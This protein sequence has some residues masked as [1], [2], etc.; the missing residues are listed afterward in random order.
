MISVTFFNIAKVVGQPPS[1]ILIYD[2]KITSGNLTAGPKS[3]GAFYYFN[4][5]NITDRTGGL[6]NVFARAVT[7]TKTSSQT[8]STLSTPASVVSINSSNFTSST[9][10]Q[11]SNSP[12][13]IQQEIAPQFLNI[14][15]TICTAP[16]STTSANIPQLDIYVS[17][18]VELPGPDNNAEKYN[19]SEGLSVISWP[20]NGNKNGVYI[21]I[22]A[23]SSVTGTFT[24]QI[25]TSLHESMHSY[26]DKNSGIYL[27]DTDDNHALVTTKDAI[28]DDSSYHVYIVPENATKGLSKSFCALS[29]IYAQNQNV[30]VA[31]NNTITRGSNDGNTRKSAY[32]DGLNNGT[33]YTV[34][35]V[36][37]KSE[38]T[39]LMKPLLINTKILAYAVPGN[40]SIEA[41]NLRDFYDKGTAGAFKNFSTTLDQY[42]CQNTSYSLVRNCSDCR[43]DYKDWLCAVSI[44]RCT[45]ESSS[46]QGILR[47][48]NQSRNP[49]IDKIMKPGSYK[50][51]LPCIELCYK[52]V[53][54]CPAFLLFNCPLSKI[55]M[56]SS[57]N[58]MV[59][60]GMTGPTGQKNS[61]G[62]S[63]LCNAM[64]LEWLQQSS[65]ISKRNRRRFWMLIEHFYGI[66]IFCELLLIFGNFFF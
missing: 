55:T 50:E 24:F 20:Y 7:S 46:D 64:G 6:K 56:D 16:N 23:P 12:D 32:F 25:G 43:R 27:D 1:T 30:T 2:Q 60:D 41:D 10:S 35:L 34:S 59:N 42:D 49:D 15:V 65:A 5:Q 48:V 18:T 4:L 11:K 29:N 47:T 14:S 13:I 22:Y 17:D 45:D 3:S 28:N 61:N 39:T 63:T 54:S 52:V 53:Q 44:P 40:P 51:I 19:T 21:G 38:A 36:I 37:S 26:D 8:S 66:I 9:S 57:Y 33:R 62:T 58:E 31:Y